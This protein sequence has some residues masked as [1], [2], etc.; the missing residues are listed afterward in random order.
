MLALPLGERGP[1]LVDSGLVNFEILRNDDIVFNE[2]I[3]DIYI[4]IFIVEICFLSLKL[5]WIS[6]GRSKNPPATTKDQKLKF[7]QA[8]YF[9]YV[10]L[11]V[12]EIFC[13]TD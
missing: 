2:A 6:R 9:I 3:F 12:K 10:Y 8:F 5:K 11:S 13:E 7:H 4:Y 1:S